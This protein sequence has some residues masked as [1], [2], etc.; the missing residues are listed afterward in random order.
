MT[1]PHVR[2]PGSPSDDPLRM[3]RMIRSYTSRRGIMTMVLSHGKGSDD[4]LAMIH[5]WA[6]RTIKKAESRT[7]EAA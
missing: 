4:I 1:T 7:S 3:L 2:Q 6:D 5:H